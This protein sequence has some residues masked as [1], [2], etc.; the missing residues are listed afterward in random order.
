MKNQKLLIAL[1]AIASTATTLLLVVI[2]IQNRDENTSNT[3]AIAVHALDQSPR[4]IAKFD[5]ID[6][7][8]NA[9]TQNSLKG[10]VHVVDFMFT[11]CKSVCIPMSN[12]MYELQ[13]ELKR[14]KLNNV[15]LLSISV[16]SK[17][18]T[19]KI[20]KDYAKVY[21]ANLNV[22]KFITGNK[23]RIWDLSNKDFMLRVEEN[24][25]SEDMSIF[26]SGR[27]AVVDKLG[28]VRGF[29]KVITDDAIDPNNA[30]NDFLSEEDKA[31]L[32]TPEQRTKLEKQRLI[33]HI[34]KL[35]QEKF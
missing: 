25:D 15:N 18:D 26:H 12:T 2:V 8:G 11:S 10:K 30:N 20:L 7:E 13:Q 21:N 34:Q 29:Y 27:F 24:K 17:T 4:P 16:D 14:L 5:L 31:K 33:L 35:S 1:L 19:P 6:Q 9:F 23:Q 28:R 32:P 22:W 3:P